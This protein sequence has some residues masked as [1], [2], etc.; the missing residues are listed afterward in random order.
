MTISEGPFSTTELAGYRLAQRMAYDCAEHVAASLWE[1][2]TE[3]ETAAMMRDYLSQRG[4]HYYFHAPFVW[5]GDRTALSLDWSDDDF[6]PSERRLTQGMPLILDVAPLV[7]GFAADIGYATCFG[8]NPL[9]EQMLADLESYRAMIPKALN[10]GRTLQEIYQDIDAAIAAQGY[11]S[12]HH[13]YPAGVI[14]HRVTRLAMGPGDEALTGGF[15]SS[16]FHFLRDKK[17]ASAADPL[18]SPYWNGTHLSDHAPEAGLW[19]V[20]PHFARDGIGV[21]FEELLVVSPEGSYWLD[22]ELPHVKRW[23]HSTLLGSGVR[24]VGAEDFSLK[25]A[26][27]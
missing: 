27:R 18:I 16:A 26:I 2:I 3:R 7:E 20:E 8:S 12:S 24:A 5:F 13:A 4:I 15:G 6:L 10:E 11:R 23:Q 9:V 22:D 25:G 21:K 1:G 19:A 14:G 17:I